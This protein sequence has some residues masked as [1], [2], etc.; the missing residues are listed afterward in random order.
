MDT[1]IFFFLKT[2]VWKERGKTLTFIYNSSQLDNHLKEMLHFYTTWKTFLKMRKR[3]EDVH[4]I[5]GVRK[6]TGTIWLRVQM[7]TGGERR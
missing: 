5:G 3:E 2:S 6:G 1:V 7:W 4:L